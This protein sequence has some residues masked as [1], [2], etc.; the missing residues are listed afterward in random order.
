VRL[1]ER[2]KGVPDDAGQSYLG[3]YTLQNPWALWLLKNEPGLLSVPP[4]ELHQTD[5]GRSP[6]CPAPREMYIEGVGWR[7]FDDPCEREMKYR[8]GAW[9]CYW[10]ETTVRVKRAVAY[11][12]MLLYDA[13]DQPIRD[14][15]KLLNVTFDVLFF[16]G[17]WRA[18]KPERAKR[19]RAK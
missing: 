11:K 7:A 10:H 9:C 13:D 15:T 2:P 1:N 8:P 4:R 16:K 5:V 12:P 17:H 19:Q 14:V 18:V 3:A 6:A